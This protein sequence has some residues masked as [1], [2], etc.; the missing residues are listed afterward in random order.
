MMEEEPPAKATAARA[1]KVATPAQAVHAALASTQLLRAVLALLLAAVFGAGGATG[2]CRGLG[3]A[4]GMMPAPL[5][6]FLTFFAS[7]AGI[8][9]A[10]YLLARGKPA[11]GGAEA[12]PAG[13]MLQ[14]AASFMGLG[15][16][17]DLASALWKGCA[18][19]GDD[20][21]LFACVLILTASWCSIDSGSAPVSN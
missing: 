19:L 5:S 1:W 9:L 17:L 20:G 10:A 13:G 3:R 2:G 15:A 18:A 11:L 14:M 21:A 8:L 6:P 16:V 12:R 7:E 4:S